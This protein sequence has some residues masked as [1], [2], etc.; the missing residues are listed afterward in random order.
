MGQNY[1]I[2]SILGTAIGDAIGL[3]YQGLSP[4]R[5]AKL[6]GIPHRYR[7]LFCWGMVSDDTE[8]TCMVVQALIAAAGNKLKF[9]YYLGWQLRFWLLGLPAGVGL[10]TLRAIV[11]LWCGCSPEKS[12]VFSAG[13]GPAMGASILGVAITDVEKLRELV[14]ISSR[15]THTDPKAEYGAFASALA[16]RTACQ[17][18]K[19]SGEHF[20]WQLQLDLG[21][22]A[23]EFIH[24]IQAVVISVNKGESTREFAN[25]Q[26]M[27]QGVSG[28]VYHS[29]PVAIRAWLSHQQ[30][31][32]TAIMTVI[33]C[34]GDTY[35][36]A[37]SVGGIVGAGVG[38]EGIPQEWLNR[39]LEQSRT[40]Q[41]MERLAIQLDNGMKLV[42]S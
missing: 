28:Y 39:L 38:K 20:L 17:T 1:I 24:I 40:V 7:F 9:Q 23:S 26:G 6:L 31:F 27:A 14:K 19:V 16:A 21:E 22:S 4:R 11:R 8:H 10:A 35:S 32:R 42:I 34:G 29:V 15:I 13:N 36:T 41:W 5:A 18:P 37:A 12:G 25:R 2:G 30:D 33:P 3:P